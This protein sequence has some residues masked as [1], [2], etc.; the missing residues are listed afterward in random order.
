MLS[1]FI[2]STLILQTAAAAPAAPAAPVAVAAAPAP[3]AVAAAPAAPARSWPAHQ[4]VKMPS[5]SPTMARGNIVEWKK[6]IGEKISPG[7]V[8]CTVE[9]DKA[10]VDFESQEDG[11]LAKILVPSGTSDVT[12]GTVLA[13]L[14]DDA[15]DVPNLKDFDGSVK[16]AAPVAAAAAAAPTAAAAAPSTSSAGAASSGARVFASPLARAFAA[17]SGVN[18]SGVA[19]TGPNS[20]IVKSDVQA[21]LLAAAAA[22]KQQAAPVAAAAAAA[23]PVAAAP[24]TAAPAAA[25]AVAEGGYKDIPHTNMRK[26]IASRLL[27]SKN[28]IPHYYITVECEVDE[29]MKCARCLI[30]ANLDFCI[31]TVSHFIRYSRALLIHPSIVPLPIRSPGFAR[32]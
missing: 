26:V 23:A 6:K 17:S 16:A 1:H 28:T 24:K 10:T 12:I 9:T 21:H 19:G 11:Y 8:Y 15:A 29:L 5:L 14:A 7:E 13:V 2:A 3:A 30:C 18:L 20:R 27:E 31:A 25:P 4:V 32:S 22:P